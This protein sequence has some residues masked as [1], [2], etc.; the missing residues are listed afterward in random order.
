MESFTIHYNEKE[1]IIEARVFSLFDWNL[2]EEMVPKLGKMV[3]E[4]NCDLLFLDF[5]HSEIIMPTLRIY[6]TPEKLGL[7]F[8]KAGVNAW[9]LRRAMLIKTGQKD[10]DF[11]EDV[12]INS[13]Q[14]LRIFTDEGDAKA[15]LKNP[16]RKSHLESES[17]KKQ[18]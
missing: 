9:S 8:S 5:T 16:L 1:G 13:A 10:F 15:W 11:L 7:E 3:L 18:A 14:T 2:I 4:K 17:L 12:T 6:K